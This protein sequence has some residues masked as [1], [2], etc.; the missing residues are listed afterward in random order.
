MSSKKDEMNALRHG[1]LKAI[2][3]AMGADI[4][5]TQK[6]QDAINEKYNLVPDEVRDAYN[7][8]LITL[9]NIP[10]EYVQGLIK[11]LL[12]RY[13]SVLDIGDLDEITQPVVE[14]LLREAPKDDE[15]MATGEER[16]GLDSLHDFLDS[17]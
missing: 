12:F 3:K 1:F 4:K 8:L 14:M 7:D 13:F 15:L 2:V 16:K 9:E 10:S 17:L 5:A 6:W 11:A